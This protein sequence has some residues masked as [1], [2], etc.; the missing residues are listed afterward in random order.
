MVNIQQIEHQFKEYIHMQGLMAVRKACHI[1][2]PLWHRY[3][4]RSD[5]L[6]NLWYVGGDFHHVNLKKTT[7][8]EVDI[9]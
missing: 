8:L 7:F 4:L 5:A 2:W 6:F 1:T 9:F 3:F